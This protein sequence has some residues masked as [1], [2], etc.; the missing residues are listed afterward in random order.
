MLEIAEFEDRARVA[1]SAARRDGREDGAKELALEEEARA[2]GVAGRSRL[3]WLIKTV[4]PALIEKEIP[5]RSNKVTLD[6]F[7]SSSNSSSKISK[8]RS[9]S[10]SYSSSILA[11]QKAVKSISSMDPMSPHWHIPRDSICARAALQKL[12]IAL[13]Q[14]GEN[15]SATLSIF[16]HILDV[17]YI[18]SWIYEVSVIHSSICLAGK[19]AF[20]NTWCFHFLFSHCRD[21]FV[22]YSNF[23]MKDAKLNERLAA[24]NGQHLVDIQG[25]TTR[26]LHEKSPVCIAL[27]PFVDAHGAFFAPRETKAFKRGQLKLTATLFKRVHRGL[28]TPFAEAIMFMWR[29][30][31]SDFLFNELTLQR[32][33]YV[34]FCF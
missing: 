14:V 4:F 8:S 30:H 21:R 11:L 15:N 33:F 32:S 31:M 6:S 20:S 3:V 25:A 29:F 10:S 16:F 1:A 17:R 27:I 5:N 24:S 23:Q 13:G 7:F 28:F 26:L 18:M 34:A 9:P 22:F 2:L 19:S 12:G